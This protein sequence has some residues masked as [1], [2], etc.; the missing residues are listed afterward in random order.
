MEFFEANHQR[1]GALTKRVLERCQK[2]R[3]CGETELLL[4]RVLL[5]LEE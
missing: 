2:R 3:G 5:D 1:G 4:E